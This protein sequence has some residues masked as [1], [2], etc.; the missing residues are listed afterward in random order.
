MSNFKLKRPEHLCWPQPTKEFRD[1]VLLPEL[2]ELP[3]PVFLTLS[4]PYCV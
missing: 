4:E 1:A 2:V 3:M